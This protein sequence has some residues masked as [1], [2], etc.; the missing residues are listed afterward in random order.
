MDLP[1]WF[2]HRYHGRTPISRFCDWG[3]DDHGNHAVEFH[4]DLAL[5]RERDTAGC[6]AMIWLG[7][8]MTMGG[9]AMQP[10]VGASEAAL[11]TEQVRKHRSWQTAR[12]RRLLGPRAT[13]TLIEK[14]RSANLQSAANWPRIGNELPSR[15]S[16]VV[17]TGWR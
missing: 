7:I 1:V 6:I 4:L 5:Q 10:M 16:R 13:R 9:P 3:D 17:V 15:P 2:H 11:E 8:W 14:E 12:L